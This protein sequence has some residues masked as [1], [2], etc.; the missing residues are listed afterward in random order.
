MFQLLCGKVDCL[1]YV[2]VDFTSQLEGEEISCGVCAQ[3]PVCVVGYSII[4]SD[5]NSLTLTQWVGK[6]QK[7]AKEK[8]ILQEWGRGNLG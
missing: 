3:P 2:L 1:E 7:R 6:R 5:L 4:S 8:G